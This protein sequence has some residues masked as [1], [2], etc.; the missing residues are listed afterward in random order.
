MTK[1]YTPQQVAKILLVS[2]PTIKRWLLSGELPGIKIGPGG[3][4]RIRSDDLV[5]Y[6]NDRY[7]QKTQ[8]IGR[9]DIADE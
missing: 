7:S 8:K 5:K 1:L 6:T 9:E 2:V 3:Y 4:W